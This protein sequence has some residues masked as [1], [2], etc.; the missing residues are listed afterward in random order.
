MA[1]TPPPPDPVFLPKFTLWC[2]QRKLRLR[3]IAA[4]IAPC[5]REHARCIQLEFGNPKRRTPD[6]DL[7]NRIVSWTRGEIQPGDF[8]PSPTVAALLAK[9]ATA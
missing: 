3:Q 2:F 4:A 5:S 8:Y 9:R 6:E 1:H 7:M